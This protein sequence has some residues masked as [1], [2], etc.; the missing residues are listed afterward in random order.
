[1]KSPW[2]CGDLAA[3]AAADLRRDDAQLVL[4]HAGDERHD[5]ADDVRVLR[6][7][8]QRQLAGRR[9]ELRDRAARLHR[10]RDQPLL[11]DAIADD[12][13]GRRERGVDVAARDGPVERDV[14]G[15]LGDA[16]A[17]RPAAAAFCGSTTAGSGS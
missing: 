17:A 15:R 6:R 11:D 16:A 12:D 13:V 10:R 9:R 2:I 4:G 1:M 7:V 8:P 5:E 3:E 14:A